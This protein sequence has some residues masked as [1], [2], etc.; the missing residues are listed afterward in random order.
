MKAE[1]HEQ[2]GILLHVNMERP[3]NK[4]FLCFGDVCKHSWDQWLKEREK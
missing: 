3:Y 2:V 4:V 1:T